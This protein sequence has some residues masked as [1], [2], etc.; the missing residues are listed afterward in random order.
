MAF[1]SSV[2]FHTLED[3]FHHQLEDLYDAKKRLAAILPILVSAVSTRSLR[4][5][6]GH[7]LVETENH[8][9][10]LEVIFASLDRKPKRETCDAMKG[11][12]TEMDEILDAKGDD[13]VRDAALIAAAQRIEHYEMAGYG[14]LRTFARQLGH[15]E[16][17]D[18]FEKIL[19]AEKKMNANLSEIA[20]S[21]VNVAAYCG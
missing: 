18:I 5:I 9:S 16:A 12:L 2:S 13:N 14:T 19:A 6:F 20:E 17:A 21:A 4:E 10:Q 7:H 15:H 8:I 11:L 3:L 1:F